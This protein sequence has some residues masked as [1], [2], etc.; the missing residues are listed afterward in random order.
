MPNNNMFPDAVTR[1][2]LSSLPAVRC[3]LM[4]LK[5]SVFKIW[6]TVCKKL[7]LFRIINHAIYDGS[8]F[9]EHSQN[10]IEITFFPKVNK[11]SSRCSQ[12]LLWT[13]RTPSPIQVSLFV[14]RL[15]TYCSYPFSL[16]AFE[17]AYKMH[18]TTSRRHTCKPYTHNKSYSSFH[19]GR[20]WSPLSLRKTI[21]PN[22]QAIVLDKQKLSIRE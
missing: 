11:H 13:P 20:E 9:E 16:L 3:W 6:R 17:H 1:Y 12:P 4:L 2:F 18:H 22:K 15:V 8:S 5:K 14:T 19:F 21:L 7:L 10:M